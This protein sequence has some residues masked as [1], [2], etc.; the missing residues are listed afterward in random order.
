MRIEFRTLGEVDL[1]AI[2]P[3]GTKP[4][5]A[6]PKYRALLA[7]LAIARPR[8]FHSRDVLAALFWPELD[9][10]RARS[11]LRRA[12]Y[13]LRQ[14]L[15]PNAL[16]TRGQDEV[17]VNRDKFWCDT[18]AFDE[19]ID[20][21]DSESALDLYRG[22]LLP[23][24]HLA[25]SAEFERWLESER[26]RLQERTTTALRALFQ[27]A[28]SSGN[29][30]AAARWLRKSLEIDPYDEAAVGR[31]IEA[32]E[33]M[34]DRAGA[35]RAFNTFS[36]R[37][38]EDLEMEPSDETRALIEHVRT[39][40][41]KVDLGTRAGPDRRPANGGSAAEA[42]IAPTVDFE[43]VEPT[44][45]RSR[46]PIAILLVGAV[47]TGWFVIS[48]DDSTTIAGDL[49]PGSTTPG[50]A[51]FPFTVSGPETEPWRD[52]MVTLLA[53][54][55]AGAEGVHAFDDRTV[56]SAWQDATS[57]T[58]LPGLTT[59][60]D[61]AREM[62]ASYAVVG[63]AVAIGPNVRL[64]ADIHELGAPD[65][66][67][68]VQ[69][70]G[71]PDSILP[72]VDRLS[73]EI[74]G[75]VL[76][77]KTPTIPRAPSIAQS[78]TSSLP[79]LKAYLRGE[80]LQRRNEFGPASAA[81][82]E[83]IA[84]DSTFALAYYR[85]AMSLQWVGYEWKEVHD[86]PKNFEL[87]LR[88]AERLPSH[89]QA[90]VKAQS[91]MGTGG[92]YQESLRLL[93]DAA[94]RHPDD[95]EI[96]YRLGELYYHHASYLLADH[97]NFL[98]PIERAA[99]LNPS[100]AL[101]R[102]HL[103]EDAFC[104]GD[105]TRADEEL[106]KLSR[107]DPD[108]PWI[109]HGELSL[110]LAFGDSTSRAHA[111]AAIDTITD[112]AGLLCHPRTF[113]AKEA[114]VQRQIAQ[115]ILENPDYRGLWRVQAQ[116]G[117][118]G[119]ALEAIASYENRN[120]WQ[121]NAVYRLVS[122]WGFDAPTDV[123][124]PLLAVDTVSQNRGNFI[125]AAYAAEH[126]RWNDYEA[127]LRWARG[128]ADSLRQLHPGLA[129]PYDNTVSALE[130]YELVQR[131]KIEEALPMLEAARERP[132]VH[133]FMHDT[134]LWWLARLHVDLGDLERA[135]RYFDLIVRED[136]AFDP[137]ASYKLG[138]VYERLGKQTEAA[139]AFAFALEAWR[140]AEPPVTEFAANARAALERLGRTPQ[141]RSTR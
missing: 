51:V 72:L 133:D 61:L 64:A 68:R 65:R 131:G 20:S 34:G 104:W 124:D 66:T 21:G 71:P 117:R 52:A 119:A 114:L 77:E 53:T 62:G 101:Y 29:L 130:A 67:S 137:Y 9:Q 141:S 60:L 41:T 15:G 70:V 42:V 88:Y 107:V 26:T 59:T 30:A 99:Q 31:L 33:R 96:W 115:P 57:G 106:T 118:L 27:S 100:N 46:W 139:D 125:A 129:V 116:Q 128:H 28:E 56:F 140:D 1:R 110:T 86:V 136:I 122:I 73:V 93:Q 113:P 74:L 112:F 54:S 45:R 25:D 7:Y 12:L 90:L 37:M 127:V 18:V 75:S 39:V 44:K 49:P 55:L 111:E 38:L 102:L 98:E 134:I 138:V 83:A 84:A 19:F 126:G 123:V 108:D 85:L 92:S 105:S 91:I 6:A 32:R 24:T 2:G 94:Q 40:P 121:T 58:G 82:R 10:D 23:G 69:V 120:M 89:E 16:C 11:N 63:S 78:L 22:E 95:A 79:A 47:L 97:R 87:A 13:E 14:D 17:G 81:Y 135:A 3:G 5:Q 4:L 76:R 50:I 36:K 80:E 8:G 103:F 132:V 109:R 48:R 43:G 35:V